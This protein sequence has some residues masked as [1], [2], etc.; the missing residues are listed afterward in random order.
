MKIIVAGAT[1]LIGREIV[2]DLSPCH[3][4]VSV[5]HS[6]GDIRV[7]ITSRDSIT[8][9]FEKIGT[10]DAL[11]SAVGKA[12]FGPLADLTD[13]GFALGLADKLMGQVNLVR[14]GLRF[15]RDNGSFTLTSGVLAREPM[16]G[17]AVFSLV[18]SGIE[19]F[20]L[21]AALDMPRGIRINAVSPP[22]AV[23]TLKALKMDESIGL[24]AR[25]FAKAYR[26]SVEG[27][28]NGQ[29]LDVRRFQ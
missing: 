27:K 29:V 8:R 20:V 3:E 25:A 2:R 10:F 19:G 16:P 15:I 12:A 13:E 22:F 18:N 23:E 1:G 6:S 5:G 4:V 14:V 28:R 11:V 21:A 9:M 7:D 17:G 24:P 26:E